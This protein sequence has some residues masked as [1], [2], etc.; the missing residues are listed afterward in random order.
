MTKKLVEILLVEDDASD[1]ELTVSALE[2]IDVACHVE[3]VGDGAAALDY[4]FA[5]G[6][7]A[8]RPRT[9]N[10]DAVLLDLKLPKIDGL[11]V[12]RQMKSDARTVNIPVIVLTASAE[13][14]NLTEAYR[15][16]VNSYVVKPVDFEQFTEAVRRLGLWL[17]ITRPPKE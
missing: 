6:A 12:L 4:L 2:K 3:L 13:D 15:L 7:Y 11:E 17:S 8:G 10:P 14:R 9:T 1:A 5:Q 16:G